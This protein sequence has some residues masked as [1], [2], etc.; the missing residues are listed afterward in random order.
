M[1]LH[2]PG[3]HHFVECLTSRSLTPPPAKPW[4]EEDVTFDFGSNEL[5][6]ILTL[7]ISEGPYP[8]VAI[9]SGSV[10]PSTGTRG[11]ATA[12][13]HVEHARE[14]ALNGFAV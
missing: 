14:L 11:G 4:V 3:C 2:L 9:I 12:Q 10:N 5:Y 6:G 13:Y 8:A 7:P 1:L